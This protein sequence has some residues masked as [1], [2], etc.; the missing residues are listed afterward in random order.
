MKS[1]LINYPLTKL[2]I[3][4]ICNNLV[5]YVPLNPISPVLQTMLNC[6]R[7]TLVQDSSSS[8]CIIGAGPVGLSIARAFKKA[9]VAYEQLDADADVGGN[10]RH[11][12]YSTAHSISSWKTTDDAD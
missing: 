6:L 5:N 10:W 9:G 2:F 8:Y 12:V 3:Y 1:R 11:G 7:G 4:P